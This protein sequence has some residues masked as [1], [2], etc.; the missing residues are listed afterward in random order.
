VHLEGAGAIYQLEAP[1]PRAE[2]EG[3]G[4]AGPGGR[5]PLSRWERTRRALSSGRVE[6]SK[7]RVTGW[8]RG[9]NTPQAIE[10]T[11]DAIMGHPGIGPKRAGPTREALIDRILEVLAENGRH[12]RHLAPDERLVVAFTFERKSVGAGEAPAGMGDSSMP[13]IPGTGAPG[14]FDPR[15]P[16]EIA[17]DLHLRQEAYGLATEAYKL[18]LKEQPANPGL[19]RKLAQALVGLGH[20]DEARELLEQLAGGSAG[21]SSPPPGAGSPGSGSGATGTGEP[22]IPLPAR[23]VVSATRSQLDQVASGSLTMAEFK[24]QARVKSFDPPAGR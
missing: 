20:L 15:T 11:P 18:A 1:M 16:P 8:L 21:G 14:G 7:V 3:A 13:F 9:G 2:P 4:E 6:A 10:L 5:E 23:L 17:G 24:R 12:F 22:P 19:R